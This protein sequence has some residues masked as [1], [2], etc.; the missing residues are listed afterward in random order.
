MLSGSSGGVTHVIQAWPLLEYHTLYHS[1]AN[2][3]RYIQLHFIISSLSSAIKMHETVWASKSL[4]LTLV[5]H[6]L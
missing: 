3:M 2:P 5:Q 6:T 1:S 4:H